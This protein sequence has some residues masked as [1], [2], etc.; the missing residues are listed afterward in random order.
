[1]NQLILDQIKV[2]V[3][4]IHKG[5]TAKPGMVFFVASLKVKG[6]T[7]DYL[8]N[9]NRSKYGPEHTPE[10]IRQCKE[11]FYGHCQLKKYIK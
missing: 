4:I 6:K 9:V 1:M 7:Y 2:K 3:S 5:K 11:V 10:L 8:F